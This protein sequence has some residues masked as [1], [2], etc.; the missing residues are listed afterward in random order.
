LKHENYYYYYH[1]DNRHI[2]IIRLSYIPIY[3]YKLI[4]KY[5]YFSQVITLE[6]VLMSILA[7]TTVSL[8]TDT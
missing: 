6:S 5:V 3:P 1:V 8:N 7:L 4:H 2:N